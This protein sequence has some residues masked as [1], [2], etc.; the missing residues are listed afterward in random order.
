MQNARSGSR[1]RPDQLYHKAWDAFSFL[2]FHAPYTYHQRLW[3]LAA[4]PFLSDCLFTSV[5][6]SDTAAFRILVAAAVKSPSA[7]CNFSRSDP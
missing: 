6:R 4:A 7:T 1:R 3:H 5:S 2:R